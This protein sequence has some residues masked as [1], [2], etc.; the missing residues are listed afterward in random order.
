[1]HFD[2]SLACHEHFVRCTC[3]NSPTCNHK[4]SF[5]RMGDYLPKCFLDYFF[6]GERESPSSHF[7]KMW[8]LELGFHEE[9]VTWRQDNVGRL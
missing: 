1:M 4:N 7:D 2:T 8:T 6:D 5:T 3:S 9:D